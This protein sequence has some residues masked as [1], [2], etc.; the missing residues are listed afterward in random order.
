MNVEFI[1]KVKHAAKILGLKVIEMDE[2]IRAS[3]DFG[4]YMK[5][6]PEAIFYVG[7]GED[8]QAIHTSS[9]DF[10]GR[11]LASA[12]DMFMKIYCM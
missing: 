1:R 3:E 4:W 9:Y 5:Q 7:N 2:A 12:V 6:I 10:N 8:Y 11:I